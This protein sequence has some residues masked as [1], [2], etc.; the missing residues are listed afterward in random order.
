MII[1][2]VEG[3]ELSVIEPTITLFTHVSCYLH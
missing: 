3:H 2:Y 1:I